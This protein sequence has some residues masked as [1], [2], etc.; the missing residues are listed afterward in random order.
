MMCSL[1]TGKW[2]LTA[3]SALLKEA[4]HEVLGPLSQGL[5]LASWRAFVGKG[6]MWPPMAR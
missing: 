2:D 5:E 3:S 4:R 1:A 6:V